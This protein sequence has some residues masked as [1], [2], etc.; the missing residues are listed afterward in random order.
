LI[1]RLQIQAQR[2][3]A[4]A[5]WK[6][7]EEAIEDASAILTALQADT[8]QL[9]RYDIDWAYERSQDV[10]HLRFLAEIYQLRGLMFL[11]RRSPK[12][13]VEDLSLSLFMTPDETDTQANPDLALQEPPHQISRQEVG[14]NYLQRAIALIELQDCQ[15]R[16]LLDLQWLQQ[17]APQLLT[18]WFHLPAEGH[19]TFNAEKNLLSFVHAEGQIKLTAEKARPKI[20]RMNPAWVRISAR[21][22]L[23][24]HVEQ[25]PA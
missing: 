24:R 18:D 5:L 21:F 10:G 17:H 23:Q 4:H 12:R 16:A 9:S 11:L 8:T 14:L 13:A 20:N 6:K 2:A 22:G 7:P 15:E 25:N 1:D 19:F 3:L